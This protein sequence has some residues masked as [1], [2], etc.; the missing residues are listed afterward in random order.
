MGS[1]TLELE[2]SINNILGSW[3]WLTKENNS[4]VLLIINVR[5]VSHQ[6]IMLVNLLVLYIIFD[7]TSKNFILDFNK[8]ATVS[9]VLKSTELLGNQRSNMTRVGLTLLNDLNLEVSIS[10]F[11]RDFNFILNSSL[12]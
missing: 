10:K 5:F 3:S 2:K 6:F 12:A 7:L 9:V 11:V 8:I 1:L 4:N